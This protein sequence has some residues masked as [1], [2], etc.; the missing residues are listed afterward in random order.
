MSLNRFDCERPA[1]SLC[2]M[3]LS[4]AELSALAREGIQLKENKMDDKMKGVVRHV[5]TA[6]GAVAVYMGFV[7]DATWM[8]V[9]GALMTMLGFAWSWMAKA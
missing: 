9:S 3:G 5:I 7:D 8:Q 6:V 2:L 4:E 1:P